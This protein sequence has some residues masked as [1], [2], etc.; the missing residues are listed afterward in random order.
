MSETYTALVSAAKLAARDILRMRKLSK[1]MSR[2]SGEETRFA[3]V[4]ADYQ[5]T[6]ADITKRGDVAE[7]EAVNL[8][9]THPDK[10]ARV[11]N[12]MKLQESC[13]EQIE[14]IK[15]NLEK[16]TEAHEKVMADIETA[17]QEWINGTRKVDAD[18]L[19]RLTDELI[20]ANVAAQFVATE[21]P[22]TQ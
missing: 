4:S 13:A 12:A 20:K 9:D 16:V 15:K 3:K 8:P 2:K 11:E 1:W 6:I 7:F 19:H 22:V 10:T 18:E 14:S 5:K 17:T 21:T